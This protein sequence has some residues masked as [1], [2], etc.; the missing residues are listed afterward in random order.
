V[1]PQG[2][3]IRAKIKEL[4]PSYN[5]RFEYAGLFSAVPSIDTSTRWIAGGNTVEPGEPMPS[6]GDVYQTVWLEIELPEGVTSF[7]YSLSFNRSFA[8]DAYSSDNGEVGGP[9]NLIAAAWEGSSLGA[10]SELASVFDVAQNGPL[11]FT[12]SAG[13]RYF[14]QVGTAQPGS[15]GIVIMD[16]SGT[17][18]GGGGGGG[19]V[20]W[21][22]MDVK[23]NGVAAPTFNAGGPFFFGYVQIGSYFSG[24]TINH[25]EIRNLKIGS[26]PGGNDLFDMGSGSTL[27]PPFQAEVPPGS[28]DMTMSGGVATVDNMGADVYATY[29]F[30]TNLTIPVYIHFEA[31]IEADEYATGFASG[32]FL[33]LGQTGG[34]IISGIFYDP[35]GASS[36]VCNFTGP[37]LSGCPPAAAGSWFTFDIELS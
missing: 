1:S 33:D 11:N 13:N 7:G 24:S 28:P 5:D 37:D 14:L 3:F 19:G 32:D 2:I 9:L 31:F 8:F 23:I 35:S 17:S 16:C 21:S 15:N 20:L 4:H 12:V 29:D 30:G 18:G 34:G 6:A 26:T 36:W 27:V 25:H 10:L 22:N